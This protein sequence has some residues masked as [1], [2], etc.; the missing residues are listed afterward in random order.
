MAVYVRAGYP[1]YVEVV[2]KNK[3]PIAYAP[4]FRLDLRRSALVSFWTEGDPLQVTPAQ[5]DETVTDLIYCMVPSE[6]KGDPGLDWKLHVIGIGPAV[7]SGSNGFVV[8]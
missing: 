3:G 2:W 8:L 7:R 6:W 5:P 4:A 1:A